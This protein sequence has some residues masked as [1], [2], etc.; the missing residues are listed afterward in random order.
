MKT[1][2]EWQ[3]VG[4]AGHIAAEQA[5][6]RMQAHRAQVADVDFE[7]TLRRAWLQHEGTP[8]RSLPREL[9]HARQ[10]GLQQRARLR[11]CEQVVGANDH[12]QASGLQRT[13]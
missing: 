13:V 8:G 7:P 12:V 6:E 2:L 10:L 3:R 4:G 9:G 5:I 11:K 1:T